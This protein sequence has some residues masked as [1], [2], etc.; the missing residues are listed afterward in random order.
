MKEIFNK[1]HVAFE[2]IFLIICFSI[3]GVLIYLGKEQRN[4][5]GYS[6]GEIISTMQ[7][8]ADQLTRMLEIVSTEGS[9]TE[10]DEQTLSSNDMDKYGFDKTLYK[11]I[12]YKISCK[13]EKQVVSISIVGTGVFD[14]HQ[15]KD[16]VSNT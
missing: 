6:D 10:S 3:S 11:S 13:E 2:I 14:G 12:T 4:A 16:Y 7:L 5:K 8:K 15:I 9:C 1:H